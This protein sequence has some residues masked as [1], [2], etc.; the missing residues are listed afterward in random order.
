MGVPD[1]APGEPR[2]Q[3]RPLPRRPQRALQLIPRAELAHVVVTGPGVGIAICIGIG[4]GI[5]RAGAGAGAASAGTGNAGSAGI[6]NAGGTR[7]IG[8]TG[9]SGGSGGSG[10][11][12]AA[13]R[14]RA[15]GAVVLWV[16]ARLL[17]HQV[18]P[19][20]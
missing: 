2:Q 8:E 5:G 10:V 1:T 11:G 4:I 13:A 19:S 3:L 9:G 6:G 12:R 14:L 18:S 17:F 20:R 15:G 7:V 16:L